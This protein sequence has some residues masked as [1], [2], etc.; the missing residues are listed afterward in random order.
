MRYVP[1]ALTQTVRRA[2]ATFPAVLITGARQTGKTTLLRTEF[3]DSHHY[4]SLERPDIRARALADPVAFLQEAGIPLIL[5]EIQYVP[6]LLH[7]IKED[8]DADRA[9]GRWLLTGSQN[10]VLMQ[11]VTQT[12]SGRIAILTLD[13][14][15][16]AEVLEQPAVSC[17]DTLLARSFDGKTGRPVTGTEAPVDFADWLLRGGFPEPR[18]NPAVDRQLWFAS[19]VQTYLE[20]DV[21]DLAQVADLSTFG[22]FLMLIGARTGQVVNMTELGRE[23]GVTGP[24]IKRWLSVLETSQIVYLLQ[25]YFRNFGKRSR[26]SPK[27]YFLD[28]GL[29]TFLLGLHT[30]E[31]VLHGPSLGA[32]AETAVIG[33]WVKAWRQAGEPLTFYYWQ[34][35]SGSEVDLII[36]R[37][38]VL[39]GLEVKATATPTP[40]HATALA[41]W[42]DLAG[43]TA[44][45]AL[46]CRV[47]RPQALRPGIRALPWHLA[48]SAQP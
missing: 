11:G 22:R 25:P 7:Y 6:E 17:V 33:E 1:R 16:T 27:L 3:G 18:L 40:H 46:A 20:R 13:P 39:Y 2:M 44:R 14:L 19:Y 36:D 15:S 32:L 34:S 28:P 9:P 47:A 31:A 45:G 23:V 24:T 43:P 37:G 21:R 38:G 26:K 30:S 12:L 8:I 35:S 41:R 42:L 29:A 5:D 10:F 4:L 48:W